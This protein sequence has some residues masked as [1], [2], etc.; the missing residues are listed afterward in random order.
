M[1]T[2]RIEVEFQGIYMFI[3]LNMIALIIQKKIFLFQFYDAIIFMTIQYIILI[4][5]GD[6]VC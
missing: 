6:R 3:L 1:E 5:C 2:P 4:L